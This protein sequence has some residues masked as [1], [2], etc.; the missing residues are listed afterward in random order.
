MIHCQPLH[1]NF[2][3][4]RNSVYW[5]GASRGYLIFVLARGIGWYRSMFDTLVIVDGLISRIYC[6][7]F[8]KVERFY[9]YNLPVGTY[10]IG[11][12]AFLSLLSSIDVCMDIWRWPHVQAWEIYSKNIDLGHYWGHT[13]RIFQALSA[14]RDMYQNKKRQGSLHCCYVKGLLDDLQFA[15]FL[16]YTFEANWLFLTGRILNWPDISAY[17]CMWTQ[18]H[19]PLI[20]HASIHAASTA[21]YDSVL[22]PSG[23]REERA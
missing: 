7:S 13:A 22:D 3:R 2:A 10:I 11:L 9:A 8:G 19:Q 1:C 4:Y 16:K 12:E 18:K 14:S 15:I 6:I 17:C 20:H 5:K 23:E 21:A